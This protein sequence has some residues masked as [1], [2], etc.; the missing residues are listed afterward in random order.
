MKS[1]KQLENEIVYH[2]KTIGKLK[3]QIHEIRGDFDKYDLMCNCPQHENCQI[4][5]KPNST[6]N[7]HRKVLQINVIPNFNFQPFNPINMIPNNNIFDN[8][9]GKPALHDAL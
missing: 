9:Q 3:L 8:Q 2:Y 1:I 6:K 5:R 7:I 4:Y